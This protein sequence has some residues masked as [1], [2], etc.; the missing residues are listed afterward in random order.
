MN[1]WRAVLRV[2]R[3]V[4][5]ARHSAVGSRGTAYDLRGAG[6]LA[7]GERLQQGKQLVGV[8]GFQQKVVETDG[9]SQEPVRRRSPLAGDRDH[10]RR[11]LAVTLVK[12]PRDCIAARSG[13]V[14]IGD[15]D[16]RP[17]EAT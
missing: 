17:K 14:D 15:D 16:V 6:S 10:E 4:T 11:E 13:K 1:L 9:A 8:A 7:P 3:Y 5:T 12:L 2:V